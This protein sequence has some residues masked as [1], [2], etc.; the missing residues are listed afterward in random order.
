M[1][2]SVQEE[3]LALLASHDLGESHGVTP[4]R[5]LDWIFGCSHASEI[6]NV[7]NTLNTAS[8]E[9]LSLVV[10]AVPA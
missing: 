1:E 6:R 8:D 5:E 10:C 2:Y 4:V 3:S 9:R 7:L